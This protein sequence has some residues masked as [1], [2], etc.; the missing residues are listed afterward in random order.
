[1]FVYVNQQC[2]SRVDS[3]GGLTR[4]S[5]GPFSASRFQCVCG[6]SSFFTFYYYCLFLHATFHFRTLCSV[7][8]PLHLLVSQQ[9]H[10]NN[11]KKYNIKHRPT[12]LPSIHISPFL[13]HLEGLPF[14][15]ILLSSTSLV[16]RGDPAR[17]IALTFLLPNNL[18]YDRFT[19]IFEGERGKYK[20]CRLYLSFFSTYLHFSPPLS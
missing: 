5:F 12:P 10:Q 2:G 14:L 9:Y 7:R 6:I 3:M 17:A 4:L 8:T 20:S 19:Q 13:S 15:L 16:C 18:F 1:M 11:A